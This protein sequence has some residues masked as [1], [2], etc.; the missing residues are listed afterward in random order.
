MTPLQV[1]AT[2]IDGTKDSKASWTTL[3]VD[4]A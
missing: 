1:L 3:D 4:D 2:G